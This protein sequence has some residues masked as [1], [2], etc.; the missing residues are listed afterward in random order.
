MSLAEKYEHDGLDIEIHFDND[1]LN[2]RSEWD[3]LGV[4]VCFHKRYVL[5]DD[6]HDYRSEDYNGWNEVYKAI[7]K[8]EDP[9]CILPLYMMDHSGVSISAG[10]GHFHATDPAGWDWGQ[11]GF[12]FARKKDARKWWGKK[13]ITKKL[14]KKIEKGLRAEVEEYDQYLRGDIYGYRVLDRDGEELGSCWGFFGIEAVKEE[15]ESEA[16]H[17][18]DEKRKQPPTMVPAPVCAEV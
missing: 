9:A 15:A 11:I 12:I 3:H 1:P 13:L 16:K 10:C 14:R 5:G 7:E 6:C 8:N 18:A 17:W 2:P 4:M